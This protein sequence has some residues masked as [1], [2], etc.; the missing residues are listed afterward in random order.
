MKTALLSLLFAMVI[1]F[2]ALGQTA[3]SNGYD[4]KG[5]K[6]G[7]WIMYMNYHGGKEKDSTKAVYKRYTTYQHGRDLYPII[8]LSEIKGR[9]E[10]TGAKGEPG[11][12]ALLDGEY[13][14]Y[15]AKGRLAIGHTFNKGVYVSNQ[16]YYAPGK[17][18]DQVNFAKPCGGQDNSVTIYY[19][20]ESG[21]IIKEGCVKREVNG[22]LIKI[23]KKLYK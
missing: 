4:A 15:D 1:S 12:P 20:D 14:T 7:K 16:V 23:D 22:R 2:A 13:I 9:I 21:K 10:T 8:T 11:K 3:A 5:K 19:F 17:M 6:D 18:R